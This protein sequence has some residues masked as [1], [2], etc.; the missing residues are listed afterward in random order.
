[1]N[2]P[3]KATTDLKSYT[4]VTE[5]SIRI[6]APSLELANEFFGNLD[7]SIKL[8]GDQVDFDFIGDDLITEY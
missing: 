3:I 5:V 7:W 2:T 6:D 1:M 4:L 8:D